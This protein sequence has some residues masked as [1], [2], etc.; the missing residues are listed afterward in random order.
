MSNVYYL[1][2]DNLPTGDV[3]QCMAILYAQSKRRIVSGVA[4]VAYIEGYGFI[5]NSV[6][7]AYDDPTYTRGML[8]ALDDKLA[9]RADGG[10]V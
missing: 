7:K 1:R 5:A 2:P 6:G 10:N 9:L 8:R 3:E 4:F